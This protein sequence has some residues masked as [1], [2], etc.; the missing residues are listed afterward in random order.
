MLSMK[1]GVPPILYPIHY[2]LRTLE[3]M[4]HLHELFTC[5]PATFQQ[6]CSLRLNDA[7]SCA[8]PEFIH[9]VALRA[10]VADSSWMFDDDS[11][12]TFSTLSDLGGDNSANSNNNDDSPG[13]Q[14]FEIYSLFSP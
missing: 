6:F 11:L 1:G 12:D 2:C 13:G 7:C 8:F 9:K 14:F 3:C 10:L 5:T 4:H